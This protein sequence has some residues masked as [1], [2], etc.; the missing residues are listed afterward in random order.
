M[1]KR[2][3]IALLDGQ[4]VLEGVAS[5]EAGIM[6]GFDLARDKGLT[7]VGD[8]LA[9]ADGNQVHTFEVKKDDRA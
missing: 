9:D 4:I 1:G 3:W 5:E 6:A 2:F 8:G 7:F